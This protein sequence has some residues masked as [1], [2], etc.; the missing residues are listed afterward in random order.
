[1]QQC[2]RLHDPGCEAVQPL[3][4]CCS[5]L[6][7]RREASYTNAPRRRMLSSGTTLRRPTPA[8]NSGGIPLAAYTTETIT[9]KYHDA[10]VAWQKK[11]FPEL[12]YLEDNWSKFF[13]QTPFALLAK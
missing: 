13:S 2:K 1:M 5:S 6:S 12:T 10:I 9:P 3:R 4:V 11:N 8:R 7:Y